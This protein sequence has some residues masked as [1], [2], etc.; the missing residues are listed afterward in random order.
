MKA[1]TRIE[2]KN[3]DMNM[4]PVYERATIAKTQKYMLPLMDGYYPVRFDDSSCFLVHE[5]R[6]RVVSNDP[7]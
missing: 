3:F 7:R 2:V 1:G 5:S 4:R 6:F